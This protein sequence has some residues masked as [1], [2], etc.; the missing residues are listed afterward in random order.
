MTQRLTEAEREVLTY[1]SR[2]MMSAFWVGHRVAVTGGHK[3]ECPYDG[4]L[5]N[6]WRRVWHNGFDFGVREANRRSA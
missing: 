3:H 5:N 4:V 2:S 6:A 1:E